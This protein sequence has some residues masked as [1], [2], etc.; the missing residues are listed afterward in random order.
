[1]ERD[2]RWNR[3]ERRLEGKPGCG[4]GKIQ[5]KKTRRNRQEIKWEFFI[6]HHNKKNKISFFYIHFLLFYNNILLIKIFLL[7]LYL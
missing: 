7:L 5:A 4:L 3:L 2:K 6:F 1:M